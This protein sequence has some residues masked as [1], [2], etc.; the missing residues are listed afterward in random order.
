MCPTPDPKDPR[1]ASF[2]GPTHR[3]D[4]LDAVSPHASTFVHSDSRPV[5]LQPPPVLPGGQHL[6]GDAA[7]PR[8]RRLCGRGSRSPAAT[9][10][11]E[12]PASGLRYPTITPNTGHAS[13]SRRASR[14]GP[15]S[16]PLRSRPA[17]PAGLHGRF[18]CAEKPRNE[19]KYLF[20]GTAAPSRH[21][22]QPPRRPPGPTASRDL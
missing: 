22:P 3:T 12:P 1:E 14:R 4:S 19:P 5:A 7:T 6:S 2:V 17:A 8:A 13:V 21:S 10:A 15:R 16:A 18:A 9:S 20:P 11:P